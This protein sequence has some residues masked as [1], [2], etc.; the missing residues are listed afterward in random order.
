M[1]QI[2]YVMS[3]KKQTVT[4]LPTTPEKCHRTAL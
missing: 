3:D 4:L 2:I 1:L